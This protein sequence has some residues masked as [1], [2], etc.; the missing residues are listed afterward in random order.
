MTALTIVGRLDTISQ[1]TTSELLQD[2]EIYTVNKWPKWK[3]MLARHATP[4]SSLKTVSRLQG[5]SHE[6]ISVVGVCV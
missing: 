1:T 5:E 4:T 6:T 2:C 3:R